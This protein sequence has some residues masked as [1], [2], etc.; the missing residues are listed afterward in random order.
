MQS[1]KKQHQLL[2][3]CFSLGNFE[4]A[5]WIALE[6]KHAGEHARPEKKL[7]ACSKILPNMFQISQPSREKILLPMEDWCGTAASPGFA[8]GLLATRWKIF[9]W[10]ESFPPK[11]PWSK[12]EPLVEKNTVLGAI[13]GLATFIDSS[14][15]GFLQ[16]ETKMHLT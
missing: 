11:G 4:R 16:T 6:R 9:S 3:A 14:V 8:S 13:F 15:G 7:A 12:L 10:Q 1:S 5:S 2:V